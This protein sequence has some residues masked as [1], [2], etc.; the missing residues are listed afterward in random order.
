MTKLGRKETVD[1]REVWP[2]EATD[3]T[4]WLAFQG[5]LQLLGDSLGLSLA[6]GR[7]EEPVGKRR[8]DVVCYEVTDQ[9]HPIKVVI[10]N[11]LEAL[12]PDHLLRAELYAMTL[13]A[14]ICIIIAQN[15]DEDLC[16]LVRSRNWIH[17]RRVD[18]YCLRMS[19][20]RVGCS[21]PVPEF[22]TVVQ[23]CHRIPSKLWT[24]PERVATEQELQTPFNNSNA[25][26]DEFFNVLKIELERKCYAPEWGTRLKD[27]PLYL[28]INISHATAK[29]SVV[30]ERGESRVRLYMT[31]KGRKEL[32][33][34]LVHH[35][36]SIENDI[37]Q[38]LKWQPPNAKRSSIDLVRD[39][40][41]TD[42]SAWDEEIEWCLSKVDLFVEVFKWRLNALDRGE[43]IAP[44]EEPPAN[45][46]RAA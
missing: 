25:I 39:T 45:E 40:D 33:Y 4:P 8:A 13:E 23:P 18:Y 26:I 41:L 37:G 42:R 10:E 6:D 16:D 44:A 43:S 22:E 29:I 38:P 2:G 30:H 34:R 12:D 14:G 1:I 27:K 7:V 32:Y 24:V 36:D 3:F 35:K 17:D 21:D 9:A 31:G 15:F 28:R 20:F 5:G 11:Q 46:A 19:V